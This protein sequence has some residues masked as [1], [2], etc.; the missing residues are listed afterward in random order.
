[1]IKTNAHPSPTS[2]PV[3]DLAMRMRKTHGS[4]TS[5]RERTFPFITELKKPRTVVGYKQIWNQHLK[6]DGTNSAPRAFKKSAGCDL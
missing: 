3:R 5:G 6:E 1:M 4:R 2:Q